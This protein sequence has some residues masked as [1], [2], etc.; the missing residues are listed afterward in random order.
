[1]VNN[2][3]ISLIKDF[4]VQSLRSTMNDHSKLQRL[5]G[6]LWDGIY[7]AMVVVCATGLICVRS[8]IS[9]A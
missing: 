6:H 7:V 2:N 8:A 3:R 1:M 4:L 5:I 9:N